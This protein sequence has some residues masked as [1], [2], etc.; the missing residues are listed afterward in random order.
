MSLFSHHT[1]VMSHLGRCQGGPFTHWELPKSHHLRTATQQSLSVI[2][3]TNCRLLFLSLRHMEGWM[4]QILSSLS[5]RLSLMENPVKDDTP[6]SSVISWL[7]HAVGG[8]DSIPS[9]AEKS[10]T[11]CK[12]FP[13]CPGGGKAMK[14]M[15]T[16]SAPIWVF[17]HQ[18]TPQCHDKSFE[19]YF[20]KTNSGI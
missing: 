5:V 20:C 13:F 6:S 16:T 18:K 12:A 14:R 11:C 10:W 1:R 8:W 7:L 19:N 3:T 4:K 15:S 2:P 9:F 17:S